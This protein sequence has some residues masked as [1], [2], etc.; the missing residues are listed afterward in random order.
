M[1]PF[2]PGVPVTVAMLPAPIALLLLWFPSRVTAVFPT[3][4]AGVLLLFPVLVVVR[5][6]VLTP[7]TP[8]LV[9]VFPMPSA[10]VLLLLP[11]ADVEPA[12]VATRDVQ[13]LHRSGV[14]AK[15][16]DTS[17][18]TALE[19]HRTGS[20]SSSAIGATAR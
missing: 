11:R 2:A 10:V 7:G 8:T 9:A 6:G 1:A 12:A 16:R 14:D 17:T 4:K 20:P 15:V 18:Y 3:P 19:L 13:V 5:R